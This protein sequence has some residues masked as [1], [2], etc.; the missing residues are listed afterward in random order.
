MPAKFKQ[1]DRDYPKDA[2]GRRMN[3]H[4]PV[5]KWIH[6]Y[7][8]NQSVQ[9]LLDAINSSR[10]KPKHKAKY[11]NELVRRGIKLVY[12]LEDGTQLERTHQALIDYA[13][14]NGGRFLN[15]K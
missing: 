3:T 11:R 10:T 9:T 15:V 7:L 14:K 6:H 8:K 2:R 1:S 13:R 4:N 5:K 12:K